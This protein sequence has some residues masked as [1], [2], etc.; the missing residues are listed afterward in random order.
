MLYGHDTI[1]VSVQWVLYL[2]GLHPE[3][4]EKIHQEQDSAL[5]ADSKGPLSVADLKELKYLECVLKV[6]SN[7]KQGCQ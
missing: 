1:T 4:Q 6:R 5:E 3:D 2:T 7:S